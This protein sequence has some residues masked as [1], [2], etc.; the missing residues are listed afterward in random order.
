M[1]SR[2]AVITGASSGIGAATARLF[3]KSGY[4]VIAAARRV[5]RLEELAIDSAITPLRLDVTNQ[6]SVDELAKVVERC[7]VLVNNAGGALGLDTIETSKVDDWQRMYDTN[8]LGTLRVTR[9]LLPAL[10]RSEN[11]DIVIL[12]S[13][14]A[15]TAY[16]G[17]GGY[18]AAKHGEHAIA[19]TLRLELC[20]EPLR[21][22]EIAP[23]MVKTEEF[24]KTRF[25]GDQQRANSVYENVEG[26]LLA[27][28][29]AGCI[30]WSVSL[31]SHVNVDTM[32]VRPRVQAAQHR[33]HK[34]PLRISN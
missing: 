16:E 15:M 13:T 4:E 31:P 25:G 17:G 21:V 11:G 28:D 34:G 19:A 9:A 20:G 33:L 24:S 26:P 30:H 2:V 3:A 23:G 8:V 22:I 27:E 5:D 1:T 32:V 10:R 7:D 6:G 18:V 12:T 29:V 14:A